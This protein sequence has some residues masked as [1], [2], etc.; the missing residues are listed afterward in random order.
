MKPK[1]DCAAALAGAA[2]RGITTAANTLKPTPDPRELQGI[3]TKRH[4]DQRPPRWDVP[5]GWSTLE[6][7]SQRWPEP[8]RAKP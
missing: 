1:R 6:M 4:A 3:A 5:R 2:A 7:L 8:G